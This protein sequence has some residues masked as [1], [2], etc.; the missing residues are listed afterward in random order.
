VTRAR[1]GVVEAERPRPD[2]TTAKQIRSIVPP[3][4]AGLPTTIFVN[5]SGKVVDVHLGEYE[6][7][8]ALERDIT[9]R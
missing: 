4:L 7:L 3:G 8:A 2:R 5:R 6:S 9:T 1:S